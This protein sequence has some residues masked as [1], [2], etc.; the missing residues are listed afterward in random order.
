MPSIFHRPELASQLAEQVLHSS[1]ASA[2]P[3]GV[4]L[5][6][7]RRTG[8]STFVREDLRPALERMGA[9]VIY[10]DLWADRNVDPGELLTAAIRTEMSKH[11]NAVKRIARSLGV[12]GANVGGIDFSLDRIGLGREVTLAQALAALSDEVK[13]PLVIVIDE[14]QHAL[15]SQAGTD[16]LFALKAARDELN[17]SSHY[18]LRLV[19]TGSNRD[20]LAMLRNSRDQAFFGAPLVNFPHLDRGYVEWFCQNVRLPAVLEPAMVWALFERAGWRPEVLGAAADTL[21]FEFGLVADEVPTR[22][23]DAVDEQIGASAT[24]ALRV[25]RALTPLQSAVLRVLAAAGKAFRPFEAATLARYREALNA[26]GEDSDTVVKVDVASVQ[27]ALQ[28]LQEKMLI[29]RA[30]RG[31]YDL[32]DG[33]VRDVLLGGSDAEG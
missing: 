4:F 16:S 28:A 30:A 26:A 14:A 32:E 7:P 27:A 2:S 9:S 24:E 5:A 19:C 10:V 29:W 13:R 31:V 25:I 15:T 3:S 17:S 6:A 12:S 23:A 21:R 18:G 1:P 22:F 20:K 11:D 8:K 33:S